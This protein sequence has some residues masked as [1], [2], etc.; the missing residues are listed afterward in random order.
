M[1]ALARAEQ[2]ARKAVHK[3]CCVSERPLR[4]L[5]VLIFP[6]GAER[7]AGAVSVPGYSDFDIYER[8]A[9]TESVPRYLDF[10]I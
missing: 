2:G 10:C 4:M 9:N 1:T 3:L 8:R 7:K 6:R 5:F